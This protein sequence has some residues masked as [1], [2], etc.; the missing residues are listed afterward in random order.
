MRDDVENGV[1]YHGV[2]EDR[3]HFEHITI[4]YERFFP[5][6]DWTYSRKCRYFLELL[7]MGIMQRD[8]W[9]IRQE[10]GIN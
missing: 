5:M 3:K 2:D 9:I 7:N 6:D 1:R 8:D 10:H 4:N